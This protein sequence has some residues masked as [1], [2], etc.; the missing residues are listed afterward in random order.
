MHIQS[1]DHVRSVCSFVSTH[2]VN[3]RRMTSKNYLFTRVFFT[4]GYFSTLQR[5]IFFQTIQY[6]FYPL[7]CI[8]NI[9]FQENAIDFE[10]EAISEVDAAS[11]D[12]DATGQ[13]LDSEGA[14]EIITEGEASFGEEVGSVAA[15]DLFPFGKQIEHKLAN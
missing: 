11:T 15:N 13:M 7:Y 4:F 9:I 1:I 3:N 10:N 6:V 12:Y 8:L 2:C 14:A 5:C